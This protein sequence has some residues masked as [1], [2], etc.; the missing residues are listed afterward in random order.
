MFDYW[1]TTLS[2]CEE[3]MIVCALDAGVYASAMTRVDRCA[4]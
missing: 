4:A 1:W 2:Q 3:C